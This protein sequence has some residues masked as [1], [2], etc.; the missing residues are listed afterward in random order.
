MG[1]LD[2]GFARRGPAGVNRASQRFWFLL[3]AFVV[4]T[5]VFIASTVRGS[6]GQPPL[7]LAY[8]IMYLAMAGFAFCVPLD[9]CA[10]DVKPTDTM[11]WSARLGLQ[12]AM[13][14]LVG[15][16]L[17]LVTL[18]ALGLVVGVLRGGWR[19]LLAP[20][21]EWEVIAGAAVAAVLVAA[22]WV[23]LRPRRTAG[24]MAVAA[25]WVILGAQIGATFAVNSGWPLLLFEITP[26]VIVGVFGGFASSMIDPTRARRAGA[27]FWLRVPVLAFLVVGL[28]MT[29]PGLVWIST[30]WADIA[31]GR[32]WIDGG[33]ALR[34]G[35]ACGWVAFFRF[36]GF[37]GVQHFVL[38]WQL[39]R[40][41]NLP[42]K[43]DG[44]LNHAVQLAL[45]QKVGFGYRFIHA[46]LLDHLAAADA[47]PA[48]RRELR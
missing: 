18:F 41:G 40:D 28:V 23:R 25:T 6:G 7:A 44:F 13:A 5:A 29:V 20:I 31:K 32:L 8:G 48:E 38:R 21:G 9:V 14:G 42:P 2:F 15:M 4:C 24:S 35:A 19:E 17:L 12:R 36:G 43:I 46:L 47:R 30:N 33:F 37:N 10:L 39:A 3:L 22:V 27:W 11:R 34:V 1:V 26:A 45:L 16:N